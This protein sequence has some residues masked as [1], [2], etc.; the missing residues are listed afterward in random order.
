ML[1]NIKS[2]HFQRRIFFFLGGGGRLTWSSQTMTLSDDLYIA[3]YKSYRYEIC[4]NLIIKI[5]LLQFEAK[6]IIYFVIAVILKSNF[7]FVCLTISFDL[8]LTFFQSVC[9]RWNIRKKYFRNIR[10]FLNYLIFNWNIYIF[11]QKLLFFSW[12]FLWIFCMQL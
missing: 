1:I 11:Q 7:F 10:L 5:V 6:I 3:I 4:T 2:L 8:N 12:F 9:C